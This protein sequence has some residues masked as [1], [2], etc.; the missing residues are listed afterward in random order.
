M[1]FKFEDTGQNQDVW[2]GSTEQQ[3]RKVV[4]NQAER[5]IQKEVR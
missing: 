5:K 1:E 4:L 2:M 3:G